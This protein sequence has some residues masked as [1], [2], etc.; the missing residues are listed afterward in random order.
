MEFHPDF[1]WRSKGDSTVIS[2]RLNIDIQWDDHIDNPQTW[3]NELYKSYK[4]LVAWSALE[5]HRLGK[6]CYESIQSKNTEI[7]RVYV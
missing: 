5:N 7:Q 4:S 2:S 1:I 6:S 3:L